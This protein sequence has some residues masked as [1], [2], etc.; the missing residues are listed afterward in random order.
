V[1]VQATPLSARARERLSFHKIDQ[2]YRTARTLIRAGAISF[3]F[4]CAY[5]AIDRV[6]GKT[7]AVSVG[8]SVL[9]DFRFALVLSLAGI[10]SIWAVAERWLR[11]RKAEVMQGRIKD[12]EK[13][14][15]ARRTTSGLTP[16]GA[17]HP[18]DRT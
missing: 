9:W 12:L 17:T 13:M 18:R 7:T 3:A 8:L 11:H 14:I 15:D 10:T 1:P 4:W 16:K 2:A 5:L 6:S